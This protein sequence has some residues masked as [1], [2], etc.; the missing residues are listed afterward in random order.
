MSTIEQKV[1]VITGATSG[2]G[3]A[4][5]RT[6]SAAGAKLML[7]ARRTEKLETLARELGSD[8]KWRKTDVSQRSEVEM[9]IEAA[10]KAFGKI[11]VL[12][13]NA[14]IMPLS[15]FA[16][17]RVEEWEQMIDVNIKGVLYGIH[18]VLGKM[19]SQGYGHI[20]NIG[21]VASHEVFASSGVYSGTKFAVWAISEGLRKE[22]AG[23]IRVTTICPGAVAT[24]LTSSIKD[25]AAEKL[26]ANLDIQ[27]ISPQNIADAIVFAISQPDDVSINE[28]IVRPTSQNL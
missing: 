10:I 26:L 14:G 7:A 6:L 11:D 3:E 8:C 4:T 12:I 1:I 17:D 21:S 15:L 2:I 19:L 25:E 20:I 16:S 23:T 13:N 28:I 18:S 27:P 5:A 24:E 22:V 9:L